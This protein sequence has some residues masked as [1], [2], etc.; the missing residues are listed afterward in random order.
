MHSD[1]EVRVSASD[2]ALAASKTSTI[3]RW[4]MSV[5]LVFLGACG[6]GD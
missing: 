2:L 6:Q 4:R 3:P 1:N 5:M